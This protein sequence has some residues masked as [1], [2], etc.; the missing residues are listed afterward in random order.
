MC[1]HR[2]PLVAKQ[3]RDGRSFLRHQLE[4][5]FAP[6]LAGQGAA[7][8]PALD[9]LLSFET[10]QLLRHDHGRSRQKTHAALTAAVSAL[11]DPSTGG[12]R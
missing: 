1:A 6:E 2:H 10:H 11:L 3:V 7:L 9:A 5:V 4:R 8:L 12:K